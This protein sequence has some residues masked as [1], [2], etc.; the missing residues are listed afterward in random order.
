[1]FRI[2]LI[3][4][5]GV[6]LICAGLSAAADGSSGQSAPSVS[7]RPDGR[8]VADGADIHPPEAV[9]VTRPDDRSDRF[10]P[11]ASSATSVVTGRPDGRQRPG[12]GRCAQRCHAGRHTNG[13][14][15]HD[16][17]RLARSTD[18]RPDG[19][20]FGTRDGRPARLPPPRA[21]PRS[22]TRQP[23]SASTRAVPRG[24][25]RPAVFCV[26]VTGSSG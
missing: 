11:G 26:G 9:T 25:P 17:V 5:V 3:L 18:R 12:L 2:P 22:L 7:Q 23:A 8:L 10:T 19:R 15:P 6:A 24:G 21:C 14:E 4:G 16:L 20:R 1:M 13:R